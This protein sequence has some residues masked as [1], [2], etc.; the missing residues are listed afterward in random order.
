MAFNGNQVIFSLENNLTA[1]FNLPTSAIQLISAGD[2]EFVHVHGI[3]E[4]TA[5][6]HP[7]TYSSI[8]NFAA[9]RQPI[10]E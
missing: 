6:V 2:K 7:Q 10:Q 4:I 8:A 3:G 5:H 9:E 1:E